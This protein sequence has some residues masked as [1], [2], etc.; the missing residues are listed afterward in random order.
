MAQAPLIPAN[1]QLPDVFRNRLGVSA[2]RQRTMLE[3][4]ELLIVA[5]E[6]P[7]PNED[8][9]RGV[10]FWLDHRNEWRASNGEPGKVAIS[11]L[12]TRYSKRIDE[13]DQAEANATRADD[14]LH[15]L[16]GLAPLVRS[17]RN[18]STVLDEA[19]KAKP[20][21]RMLIEQ[22]DRAYETARRCELLYDD[23]KNG[24]DIAVMRRVEEQAAAAHQMSA[25]SHRLNKLAAAFFPLATLGAIFGTTLTENWSWSNSVVPFGMFLIAGL[26]GGVLLM[27]FITRPTE[28]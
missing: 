17:A 11:N 22:R 7:L 23:A 6:A 14:Y 15:L 21:D 27:S 24:M 4:D 25:A 5:H 1:W 12:L 28:P 9:R 10:L 20:A 26:A 8:S 19:R 13:Y 2:G 3:N 18:L 16:E